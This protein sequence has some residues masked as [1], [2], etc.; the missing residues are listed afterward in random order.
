MLHHIVSILIT[1]WSLCF[2]T[3]YTHITTAKL[4]HIQEYYGAT[5]TFTKHSNL[6]LNIISD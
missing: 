4:P 2:A 1:E 6:D 3:E 5:L